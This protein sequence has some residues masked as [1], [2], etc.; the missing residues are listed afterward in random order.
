MQKHDKIQGI[1]LGLLGGVTV[2]IGAF[3]AHGIKPLVSSA[4][5]ERFETGLLFQIMHTLALLAI[6]SS[7]RYSF[8][9]K[10]RVFRWFLSGILLFSGSLYVLVFKDFGGGLPSF[11]GILTPVGGLCFILGWGSMALG[12]YRDHESES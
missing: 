5:F 6:W 12:V 10:S 1:L 8:Q 4:A 9:L 7:P 11:F 2:V 3:G